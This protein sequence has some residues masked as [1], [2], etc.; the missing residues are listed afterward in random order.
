MYKESRAVLGINSFYTKKKLTRLHPNVHVSRK[1]WY[2]VKCLIRGKQRTCLC[3]F[4]SINLLNLLVPLIG[5]CNPFKSSLYKR[6]NRRLQVIQSTNQSIT[7]Y[8]FLLKV[9][10]KQSINQSTDQSRDISSITNQSINWSVPWHFKYTQSINQ[11]ISPM[12]FQVNPINQSI[13][14]AGLHRWNGIQT[15]TFFCGRTTKK[16]CASTSKSRLSAGSTSATVGGITT[17][18]NSAT[19][20][21]ICWR[22]RSW[23]LLFFMPPSQTLEKFRENFSFSHGKHGEGDTGAAVGKYGKD[24]NDRHVQKP[25][26]KPA[27]RK[28]PTRTAAMKTAVAAPWRGIRARMNVARGVKWIPHSRMV[29]LHKPFQ[30]TGQNAKTFFS[31]YITFSIDRL[32]DWSLDWLIDW[33]VDWLIDCSVDWLIDWWWFHW[34]VDGLIDWLID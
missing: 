24:L 28:H 2:H 23:L 29:S 10:N 11:L 21:W 1:S 12:T 33:S 19:S 27:L 26:P 32:I 22:Y 20:P 3:C 25:K 6:S 7:H 34:W 8:W 9:H 31:I 16:W 30:G 18:T 14:A 15:R 13:N 17:I 5:Y 4:F